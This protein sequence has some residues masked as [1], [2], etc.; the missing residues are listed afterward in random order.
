MSGQP[1]Q[2]NGR[3]MED[4]LAKLQETSLN[5]QERNDRMEQAIGILGNQNKEINKTL[6]ILEERNEAIAM[7][8]MKNSKDIRSIAENQKKLQ[9][10]VFEGTTR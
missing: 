9:D 2:E 8:V 1:N 7:K 10:N 3:S 5:M 6:D 4:V